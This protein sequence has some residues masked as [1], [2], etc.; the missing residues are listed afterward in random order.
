MTLC[1][2]DVLG[3]EPVNITWNIVRGDT[4]NIRIDFLEEDETTYYDISQWQIISTVYD[5]KTTIF[6]EISV[7]KNQGWIV[8]TATAEETRLWG[9]GMKSRLN[10]L[11]FDVEVILNDGSVWTPV[12]GSISL[13]G[14]VT[15]GI[16]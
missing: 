12:K 8:V 5:P 11:A 6:D 3:L 16:L 10:E 1:A 7:T 14:D 4:A 15:G 13:I 9:N 2:P